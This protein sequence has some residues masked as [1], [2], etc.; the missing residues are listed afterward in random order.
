M[1]N[2]PTG[3]CVCL[4]SDGNRCCYGNIGASIGFQ[5]EFLQSKLPELQN[6]EIFYIESFF[7]TG[8]RF[9]ICQYIF[10]YICSS[11]KI[12]AINLSATYVIKEFPHEIKYLVENASILFGNHDEFSE[13]AELFEQ[14]NVDSVMQYLTNQPDGKEKII[15]CTNGGNDVVFYHKQS[16]SV[17]VESVPC[18]ALAA[19]QIIDTTG[20]GDAFV[21]GFCHAYLKQRKLKDCVTK[22]VEIATKMSGSIVRN[23]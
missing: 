4:I 11:G 16:N 19:D 5:K 23:Q 20:C 7:I 17:Q 2:Q 1:T 3:K 15:I 10:E 18:E 21:A 9:A 13:L 8:N 14:P 12:L 22:G 6:A